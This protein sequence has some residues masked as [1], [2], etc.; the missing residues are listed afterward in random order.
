MFP[1]ETELQNIIDI[2]YTHVDNDSKCET[3][4]SQKKLYIDINERVSNDLY[5]INTENIIN[6][7]VY[8]Y[9]KIRSG[10]YVRIEKNLIKHFI[11]FANPLFENNWHDNVK[12]FGV[13]KNSTNPVK[14]YLKARQ[15]HIRYHKNYIPNVKNWWANAFII[16]NEVVEDVWGQHSLIE[17]YDIIDSVL[18]N[19]QINNVSFIINKR[20]HPILHKNL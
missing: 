17:Y 19:K 8:V 13:N 3:R 16:N 10:I 12:L 1:I 14:D 6:T 9:E 20:D 11:P 2:V 4:K 5:E 15:K 7:L 18:R